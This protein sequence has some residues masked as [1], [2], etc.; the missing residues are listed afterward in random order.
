MN[1]SFILCR[2]DNVE[3]HIKMKKHKFIILRFLNKINLN[4]N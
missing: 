1:L 3:Y 2:N 4:R